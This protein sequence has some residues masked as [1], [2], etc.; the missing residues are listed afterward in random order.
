M[1]K[2]F[3][4]CQLCLWNKILLLLSSGRKGK[5]LPVC[6][7][8]LQSLVSVTRVTFNQALM[9][10]YSSNCATVQLCKCLCKLPCNQ[11]TLQSAKQQNIQTL[12]H[13]TIQTLKHPNTQP[14][15]QPI[16]QP[17]N[18]PNMQ[19]HFINFC[20]FCLLVG[21]AVGP[22]MIGPS[23]WSAGISDWAADA[24]ATSDSTCTGSSTCFPP[25]TPNTTTQPLLHRA[26]PVQRAT[27]SKTPTRTRPAER[28]GGR[29][30]CGG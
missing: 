5:K 14:S 23:A 26:S 18:Q 12:K 10:E 2:I 9:C 27:P 19:T 25:P 28:A 4:C 6:R 1:K 15:N 22:R 16:K 7:R 20:P 3:H 11:S 8:L 21:A 13:V 29:G 17:C 24:S 30:G